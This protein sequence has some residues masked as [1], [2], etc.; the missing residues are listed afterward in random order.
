MV[1]AIVRRIV[2]RM[3]DAETAPAVNHSVCHVDDQLLD[4]RKTQESAPALHIGHSNV[5]SFHIYAS[6]F[7]PPSCG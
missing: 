3:S 2:S 4:R 5:V 7:S 1:G 6:W